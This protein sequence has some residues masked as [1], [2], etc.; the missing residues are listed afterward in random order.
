MMLFFN[1]PNNSLNNQIVDN[2]KLILDLNE[3]NIQLERKLELIDI[4]EDNQLIKYKKI[5]EIKREINENKLKIKKMNK[6]EELKRKWYLED[7]LKNSQNQIFI[8]KDSLNL[9]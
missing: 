8:N 9:K 1:N 2:K 5:D 6:I 3:K 4:V 7:S